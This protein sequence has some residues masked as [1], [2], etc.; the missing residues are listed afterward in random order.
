VLVSVSL[1]VWIVGL[2]V[3]PS[4][5]SSRRVVGEYTR[6]LAATSP[7]RA[8]AEQLAARLDLQIR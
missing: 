4:L 1:G 7:D 5:T 3:L 8:T 6:L 2:F